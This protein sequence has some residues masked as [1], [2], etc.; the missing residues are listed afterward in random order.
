MSDEIVKDDYF[1]F[2]VFYTGLGKINAAHAATKLGLELKPD[3]IVNLRTAGCM[4]SD[5]LGEAHRIKSVV[6]HDVKCEPL[7]KRGEMRF[8]QIESEIEISNTGMKLATG[9]SFI[10]SPDSWFESNKIDLVDMEFYAIA[11]VAKKMSIPTLAIKYAS[12]MADSNFASSWENSME[13]SA[14]ALSG[15]FQDLIS[16]EL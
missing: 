5:H 7:S 16:K 3:I 10:T 12:D 11:K 8:D 9:D 2:R 14:K 1:G 6:E 15:A 4:N 13:K